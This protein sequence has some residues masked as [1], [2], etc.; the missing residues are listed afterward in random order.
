M[1][2]ERAPVSLVIPTFDRRELIDRALRSL[3][4]LRRPPAEVIVVDDGSSD[5]TTAHVRRAFPSARLVTLPRR[6]GP[7]RARNAALPLLTQDY[8]WFLDSDCEVVRDDCLE[9]MVAALAD[10]A[11]L[12]A[13][14]GD[15][16]TRDLARISAKHL[17]ASGQTRTTF[18]PAPAHAH[19]VDYIATCNLLLRRRELAQVGGFHPWLP[20][21]EDVELCRRLR[22]LGLALR[23]D[24]RAAVFHDVRLAGRKGDV[25]R[26]HTN[27]IRYNLLTMSPR[28]LAALPLHEVREALDPARRRSAETLDPVVGKHL[29]PWLRAAAARLPPEARLALLGLHYSAALGAAY[30]VNAATLPWLLSRRQHPAG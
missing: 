22:R 2:G 5:G 27:R 13:I 14:G 16:L 24:S 12:G 11:S 8:C 17:T 19:P 23:V 26:H 29:P 20:L 15:S 28:E 18:V 3:E 4:R 6:L 9:F 10:D 25:F 7:A 30:A 1:T 21:R